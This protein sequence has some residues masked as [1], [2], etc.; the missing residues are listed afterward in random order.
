MVGV[1]VILGKF[2]SWALIRVFLFGK[3]GYFEICRRE[4]W[5][6]LGY[7]GLNLEMLDLEREI[8]S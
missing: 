2:E 1:V 4:S 3:E 5:R 8:S 7:F 6:Y